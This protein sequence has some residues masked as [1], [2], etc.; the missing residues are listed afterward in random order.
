MVCVPQPFRRGHSA[1]TL[2]E[3]LVVIA[4]IATLAAIL[5]PVFAQAKNAAKQAT[6]VSNSRQMGTALAL[7]ASDYDDDY[8]NTGD[9]YLWVG[10]RMRWPI[11]PYLGVGQKAKS[12]NFDSTNGASALLLCPSDTQSGSAYDATSY[13]YSAAFY[14]SPNQIDTMRIRNLVSSLND[15]GPGAITVTQSSSSVVFP[16]E[17][18]LV[19]EWFDSHKAVGGK[20][21]GPW[22]TLKSGLAP[23]DDRWT[24]ARVVVF[25]DAHAKLLQSGQMTP[26]AEDCPDFNLT[27]DGVGG[28]DVRTLLR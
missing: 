12:G 7:Y 9:P 14:H 4:I 16:A 2:I 23:G 5:F 24:G 13:A 27:P 10:R 20:P 22:G 6:C 18:V 25:A 21:I 17:K 3:L 1:F 28:S 15:A 19:S 11:M 8:P 26:S